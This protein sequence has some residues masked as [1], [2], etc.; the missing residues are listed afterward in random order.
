MIR[1]SVT[2]EGPRACGKTHFLGKV[3]ELVE[4]TWPQV[5]SAASRMQLPNGPEQESVTFIIPSEF[6]P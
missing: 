2:I 3:R 4:E 1:I 6:L 5:N